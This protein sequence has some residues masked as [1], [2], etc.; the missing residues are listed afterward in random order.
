MSVQGFTIDTDTKPLEA[1]P[2]FNEQR[3]RAMAST[4]PGYGTVCADG[5]IMGVHDKIH[6]GKMVG[7]SARRAAAEDAIEGRD[8]TLPPSALKGWPCSQKKSP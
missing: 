1:L 4:S 6:G 3:S 5:R 8:M 2:E 7:R